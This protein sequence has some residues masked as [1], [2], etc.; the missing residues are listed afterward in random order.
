MADFQ[1]VAPG[2]DGLS[3]GYEISRMYHI[4]PSFKIT[5]QEGLEEKGKEIRDR[6][7]EPR[8]QPDDMKAQIFPYGASTSI[9]LVLTI[10]GDLLAEIMERYRT[11]ES[12]SLKSPKPTKISKVSKVSKR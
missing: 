9:S 2:P 5:S 3:A 8:K 11:K 7:Y 1:I 4:A 12:K 10:D 6:E